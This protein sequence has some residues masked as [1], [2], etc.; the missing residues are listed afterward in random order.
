MLVDH[1]LEFVFPNRLSFQTQA[2]HTERQIKEEFEKLHQFLRDEEGARI[3]ALKE[4]EEQ[5]MRRKI[6]EMNGEI[7]ALSDTIRNIE[8]EMEAEDVLFLQNFKSTEK[9]YMQLM[10]YERILNTQMNVLYSGKTKRKRKEEECGQSEAP[11]MEAPASKRMKRAVKH[12]KSRTQGQEKAS[13]LDAPQG[14][15]KQKEEECG[16]SVSERRHNPKDPAKN[17]KGSENQPKTMSREQRTAS[18]PGPSTSYTIAHDTLAS[19]YVIGERLGEGGYAS[20]F[21]GTR[22]SD[23]LQVAIK[24]VSKQPTDSRYLQSPVESKAVP[25]E[26]ALM[27]MVNEP[28]VCNSIIKLIEW[29]DEPDQYILVLERPDPCVDLKSFLHNLGGYADEETARNIMLLAVEA[30]SQCSLRGVLHRDIKLENFLM[31]TDTLEV[32]LIDFGCGDKIRSTGYTE[33]EGTIQYCPP[34]FFLQDKYYADPATIWSLGVLLFT[35]VCGRFPFANE[36]DI[37]LGSLHFRDGLSKEC[38]DLIE[39][40][41]QRNPSRRPSFQQIREHEWFQ[42]TVQA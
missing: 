8:K 34:D 24:F 25:V 32:K 12:P 11:N 21:K 9:Q 22:I 31:N 33:Y 17:S 14:K 3:A 41:L 1:L 36:E 26:V 23:G 35:M 7:S 16:Q 38:C 27:Q 28:P 37:I 20:V 15:E 30:A 13:E 4:E 39:W 19:Q 18:E 40:C 29:F 5:M 10:F 42:C 6:E 2:Q